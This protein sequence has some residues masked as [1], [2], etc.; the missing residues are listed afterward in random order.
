MIFNSEKIDVSEYLDWHMEAYLNEPKCQKIQSKFNEREFRIDSDEV[1]YRTM[2]HWENYGIVPKSRSKDKGWRRFSLVELLWIEIIICLREF[3]FSL[4]K[5][6]EVKSRV[7]ADKF[8][9]PK[10]SD[11]PELEFALFQIINTTS[12][13]YMIINSDKSVVFA[14]EF[15]FESLRRINVSLGVQES[16]VVIPLNPLLSKHVKDDIKVEFQLKNEVTSSEADLLGLVR[17]EDETFITV[18]SEEGG[19]KRIRVRQKLDP[20]TSV[21]SLGMMYPDQNITIIQRGNKKVAIEQEIIKTNKS[22]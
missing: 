3:G 10:S 20:K 16:Y 4:K 7:I 17:Q 14:S 8:I 1:S 18:T 2:N 13:Y 5:I 11:Y 9:S 19:I 6:A 12:A 22:S 21:S 15:E